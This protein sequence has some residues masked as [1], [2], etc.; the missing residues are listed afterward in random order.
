MPTASEGPAGDPRVPRSSAQVVRSSVMA[1]RVQRKK[2]GRRRWM[3]IVFVLVALVWGM[4]YVMI[5]RPVAAA[6]AAGP[7]TA[8]IRLSAHFRFFVDP[9]TLALDLGRV[10]V[11]DTTDVFRGLL[12]AAEAVA[13][14]SWGIP[15]VTTLSRDGVLVY[16]IAGDDLRQLAH[17]FSVSRRPAAV[18]GGLVRALRQADGRPLGPEATVESAAR[19]WATGSP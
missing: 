19:R 4:N 16:T 14:A 12:A 3:V 2:Q 11:T 17:D 10:Q 8:G 13:S 6:L 15:G 7:R 5:S 18:L 9:T 1:L